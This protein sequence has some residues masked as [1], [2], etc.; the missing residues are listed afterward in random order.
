MRIRK[1]SV[2]I[3]SNSNSVKMTTQDLDMRISKTYIKIFIRKHLVISENANLTL[4]RKGGGGGERN[5]SIPFEGW[6]KELCF[7]GGEGG[8]VFTIVSIIRLC[9]FVDSIVLVV[10]YSRPFPARFV[11]VVSVFSTVSFRWFR[12]FSWFRFG[13]LVFRVL[14]HVKKK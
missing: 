3:S 4:K 6:G 7:L 10:H 9:F 8:G 14:A 11:S 1:K 13:V 5:P 12:Y 2:K